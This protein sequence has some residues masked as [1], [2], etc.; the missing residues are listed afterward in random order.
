[1]ATINSIGDFILFLGKCIVTA[2]TGSIGL[3]VLKRNKELHFYAA[4]TL[5]ICIFSFFIAHCILSLYEV[6]T[7]TVLD[8][9]ICN[10]NI[11]IFQMVVDT[12]FMCV[13]EDRNL[14]GADGRWNQ[15]GLASFSN[16]PVA[17][18]NKIADNEAPP[19]IEMQALQS[20]EGESK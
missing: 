12:L 14:N 16:D 4:P 6:C 7:F 13:C 5:V 3:I 19:P 17:K 8:L 10:I 15:S 1:M 11:N 18:K 20:G 9:M 2:I